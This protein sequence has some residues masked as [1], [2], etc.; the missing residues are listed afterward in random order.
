MVEV[1]LDFGI[2]CDK[3]VKDLLGVSA[4]V[5]RKTKKGKLS[6]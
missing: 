3:H 2:T 6:W 4:V 1:I 5:M